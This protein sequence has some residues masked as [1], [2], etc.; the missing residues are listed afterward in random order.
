MASIYAKAYVT[1]IAAEAGN[2]SHGLRGIQGYTPPRDYSGPLT[3]PEDALAAFAGIASCLDY[4]YDGGFL[5]GPP[6]IFFDASILWSNDIPLQ[7]RL[8]VKPNNGCVTLPSWSWAGWE[9]HLNLE[10][11][12]SCVRDYSKYSKSVNGN[13]RRLFT[14]STHQWYCSNEPFGEPRPICG[15]YKKYRKTCTEGTQPLPLGWSHHRFGNGYFYTHES[16]PQSEFW[17]PI[18]LRN[19]KTV[20]EHRTIQS[21]LLCRTRRAFFPAIKCPDKGLGVQL[22]TYNGQV[23]ER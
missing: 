12:E 19:S 20:P 13:G 16:D 8:P 22:R 2:A 9:G 4:I 5:C 14:K 21:Y 17:Y 11:W 3:D 7:R 6:E 10:A 15:D 18:P 23:A 1:I